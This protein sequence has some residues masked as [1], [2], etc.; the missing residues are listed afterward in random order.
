MS[1]LNKNPS[2]EPCPYES[3]NEVP[4]RVREHVVS[5]HIRRGHDAEDIAAMFNLPVQWVQ[6]LIECPPGS[7]QH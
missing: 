5:V 6:L 2:R 1:F 7:T 3:I 4:L